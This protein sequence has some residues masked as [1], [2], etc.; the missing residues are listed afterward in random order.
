MI[1]VLDVFQF[2]LLVKLLFGNEHLKRFKE[3]DLP[4]PINYLMHSE[5]YVQ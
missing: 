1:F 2:C 3:Q 5:E 4:Y